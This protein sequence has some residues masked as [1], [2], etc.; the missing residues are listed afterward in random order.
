MTL[1]TEEGEKE[2]TVRYFAQIYSQLSM[3]FI[4]D[5]PRLEPVL[6]V[7]AAVR[8]THLGA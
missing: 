4:D 3:S 2:R 7:K 6:L 1:E 8:L 5:T